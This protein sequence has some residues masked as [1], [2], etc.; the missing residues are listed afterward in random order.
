MS[1][2][3]VAGGKR[4]PDTNRSYMQHKPIE[5]AVAWHRAGFQPVVARRQVRPARGWPWLYNCLAV[6]SPCVTGVG[7]L[8][9][10]QRD[11]SCILFG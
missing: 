6:K 8:A 7:A 11:V 2:V 1:S 5:A 4:M 3:R 9:Y 10:K